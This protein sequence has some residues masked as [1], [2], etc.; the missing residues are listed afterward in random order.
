MKT[1]NRLPLALTALAAAALTQACAST[2]AEKRID[3][4]IAN[5]G[6]VTPAELNQEARDAIASNP[7]LTPKQRTELT[8]LR[9]DTSAQIAAYTSESLK[10]RAVLIE[11]MG[12]EKFD[13]REINA[14]KRKLKEVENKKLDAMISAIEKT[15][16]ILGRQYA[17]RQ[18]VMNDIVE[19]RT[20]GEGGS[21][22]R[23][24]Q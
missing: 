19:A 16:S 1:W 21:A 11:A 17:N 3:N 20:I 23:A 6:A 7:D 22:E 9:Q 2:P 13:S 24:T 12:A 18:G 10:I 15:N 4:K 5:E 14:A 8:R